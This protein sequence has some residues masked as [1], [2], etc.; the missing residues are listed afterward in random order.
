MTP[1]I[2]RFPHNPILTPADVPPSRP[3]MAVEL[4]LNPGAF[5]YQGRIGL[6][7]RVAERPIQEPGWISTPLLDP[8]APGGMTILRIRA[9]DPELRLPPGEARGFD[10]KG[11]GYLTTLSHLRL[12][13]SDDDGQHFTP[14]AHPALI[15]QGSYETFGIEDCR[16]EHIDGR[17]HL[18]YSTSSPAGVV[19]GLATTTDWRTF[20]RHGV[21]FPPH[22]KDV[23]LFP[24]KTGPA[25]ARAWTAFHRP[26]GLG[27][28][29]H[30]IWLARSP[31]MI[32]WGHH[33]CLATTRPNHWDS[34]R[35]GA[36]AAPIKTDHGWLAIYHGSDHHCRYCLG[37]L[38]L[39][40]EDPTK[41]LA[42]SDAPL[43]SPDSEYERRGFVGNVVFT[44]GHIVDGD[45]L[46]LYYG[47]ADTV[48]C[49]A[50]LSIAEILQH[51]GV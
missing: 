40:L 37:A 21:I 20:E 41:I 24:E 34:E 30:Y 22:N 8:A 1:A 18:T 10:Y 16:V 48:I 32:H 17:Y 15:G 7:L 47:A 33:A 44:N 23:A 42:R 6:L 11:R 19:A 38:L 49:A 13:W 12:A 14:D 51:L 45:R 5:R 36:G 29:G 4:L 25:H 2:H 9:D 28:G 31:D 3:D 27:P 50:T 43:M 26:S 46:T 35:I 39:D